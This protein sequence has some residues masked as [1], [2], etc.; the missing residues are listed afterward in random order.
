MS[1]KKKP[2]YHKANQT[3]RFIAYVIDWFLGS[4]MIMFPVSM[5]YLAMTNDIESVSNANI[6]VIYQMFG[7]GSALVIGLIAAVL[8]ILYYVVI[9][10]ILNGQTIGKKF[11]ELKIVNTDESDVSFTTMFK[12]QFLILI[13]FETYIYS[14]SHLLIY[15]LELILNTEVVKYFY[16]FGML[17]SI[18]SCLLVAFSRSHMAVH[19]I[20]AK[21]KVVGLKTANVDQKI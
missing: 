9:P 1:K 2:P 4:L 3:K 15:M 20:F 12:R 13:I 6:A 7:K 11:L 16:S 10:Y 14:V 18:V 5:Y 21:T 19:D 17:V 8:G